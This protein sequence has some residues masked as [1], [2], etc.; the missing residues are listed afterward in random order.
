MWPVREA[1]TSVQMSMNVP[2]RIMALLLGVKKTLGSYYC[3]CP[4]GFV[5][6]LDGKLC[7][8]FT[9]C[10]SNASKCSHGCVLTS[11]PL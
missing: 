6:L 2:S 10:P 5:L 1:E 11:G 3:T 4:A 9:S 7:H 8:E